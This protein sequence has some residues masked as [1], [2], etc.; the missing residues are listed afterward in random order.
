M[1]AGEPRA[2]GSPLVSVCLGVKNGRR[3]I[4]RFVAHVRAQTYAPIELVIVDNA[5]TDGTAEIGARLADRFFTQGPERSAQRNRAIRESQGEYVLVLDAD[6]Y[7][8]PS[9]VA[10]AVALMRDPGV[11]GV[12]VPEDTQGEG[13]W[14]RC[15]KFERDFYLIGDESVEAARFFRKSEVLAVGAYDER[16]TGP[17]DWDLSDR[18]LAK[19][20]GF[21]RTTSTLLHDEGRIVLAELIGKK[22]YY[23]A[24]GA[25]DYIHVTPP[26]RRVPFPLRPSVRKQWRRFL[27]HPI[28]GAGAM[29]MKLREGMTLLGA[30]RA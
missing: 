28:L 10:D 5:S 23:V 17:E 18:M 20:G 26:H 11:H 1:S 22:R 30:R 14:G 29:Y 4:A 16:L 7:L 9:V 25:K 15:K 13:F 6:Q 21:A 27:R 8:G 24:G 3:T 2:T 12:I 19:Y